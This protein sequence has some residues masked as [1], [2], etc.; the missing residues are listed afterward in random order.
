MRGTIRQRR[1]ASRF[2]RIVSPE[3]APPQTKSLGPGS[4]ASAARRSSSSHSKGCAS[5]SPAMS[6][7]VD[8][9]LP[10]AEVLGNDAT[11]Y[12]AGSTRDVRRL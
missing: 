5:G 11:S 10:V 3:P 12:A 7:E 1:N 4:T 9:V 8:L 6:A 2:A